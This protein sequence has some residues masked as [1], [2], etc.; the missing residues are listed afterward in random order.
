MRTW[1][2]SRPKAIRC[3]VLLI[4]EQPNECVLSSSARDSR[5]RIGVIRSWSP[6]LDLLA[7]RSKSTGIQ[8]TRRTWSARRKL[9]TTVMV[10]CGHLQWLIKWSHTCTIRTIHGKGRPKVFPLFFSLLIFFSFF[11][12][13]CQAMRLEP[14]QIHQILL[15]CL[16]GSLWPRYTS[17]ALYSLLVSL[18]LYNKKKR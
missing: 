4:I 5:R 8:L 18:S 1:K 10:C 17:N 14:S 16:N 11:Y 2:T 12:D 9:Q 15:P 3:F 13:N 7:L 6:F